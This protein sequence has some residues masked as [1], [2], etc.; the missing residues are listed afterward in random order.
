MS[1]SNQQY[2]DYVDI[3]TYPLMQINAFNDV[4]SSVFLDLAVGHFSEKFNSK[5]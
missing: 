4:S 2:L 5:L 1:E 3:I